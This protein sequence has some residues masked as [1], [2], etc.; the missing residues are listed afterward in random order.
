[1]MF[2][3]WI[4][5][6]HGIQ[7]NTDIGFSL[8]NLLQKD[9]YTYKLSCL[10]IAGVGTIRLKMHDGCVCKIQGVHHEKGVKEELIFH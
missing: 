7:I 1:M 5:L 8:K 10:E 4:K 9:L 3:Q 6:Q 2:R